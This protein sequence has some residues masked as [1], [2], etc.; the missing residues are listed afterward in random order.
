MIKLKLK[1]K[2]FYLIQET[3]N[4]RMKT[5]IF[6]NVV[7]CSGL[8]RTFIKLYGNENEYTDSSYN[9]LFCKP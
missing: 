9:H 5:Y 2:N 7:Y 4:L 6:T 3:I 1:L 8:F